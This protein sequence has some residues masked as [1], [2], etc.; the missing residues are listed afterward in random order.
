VLVTEHLPMVARLW[1]RAAIKRACM[2]CVDVAITMSDANAR[3]LVER[4]GVARARVR[5]VPNGVPVRYGREGVAREQTRRELGFEDSDVVVAFVGNLLPHKGLLRTIHALSRVHAVPWRLLVAGTGPEEA[6]AREL[7]ARLAVAGRVTFVGRQTPREVE[8]LLVA[9]DVLALPSTIEG[10]PYTILEAMASS[11]PV[12][13]SPV[14]GIP[15]AVVDGETGLLV[16]PDDIEGLAAAFAT[17]GADAQ[18]RARMGRAGRARFEE[19]FTLER[20]I[21]RMVTLYRAV[22]TGRPA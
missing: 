2:T 12:V 13:S 7:S 20:H 5:V 17:L 19:R 18:L 16:A 4:Q 3:Y 14:F 21:E 10:L 1:K 9:S 8:R 15:E 22:A 6:R 11:R